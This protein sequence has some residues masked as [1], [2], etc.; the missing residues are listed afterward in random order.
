VRQQAAI[1]RHGDCSGGAH[2]CDDVSTLSSEHPRTAHFGYNFSAVCMVLHG[3][4]IKMG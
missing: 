4:G 2:T 3:T 1:S